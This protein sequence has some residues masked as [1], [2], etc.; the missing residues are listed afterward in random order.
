MSKLLMN[1]SAL[2]WNAARSSG[3]VYF[4]QMEMIDISLSFWIQISRSL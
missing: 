2:D 3:S 4:V 1:M